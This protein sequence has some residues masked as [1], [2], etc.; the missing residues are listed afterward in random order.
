MR[1]DVTE[2]TGQFQP[3]QIDEHLHEHPLVGSEE[4]PV[5]FGTSTEAYAF[6]HQ[7]LK[8][9]TVPYEVEIVYGS[10]HAQDALAFVGE[11]FRNGRSFDNDVYLTPVR[12]HYELSNR[13]VLEI[14][15]K[16]FSNIY[17]IFPSYELYMQSRRARLASE[18]DP[19]NGRQ[20]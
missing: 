14:V 9:S 13:R 20:R 16:T 15:E 7:R 2:L 8:D 6:L 3:V 11:N 10:T 17:R 12:W 1:Y 5:Q 18:P 4:T 19:E